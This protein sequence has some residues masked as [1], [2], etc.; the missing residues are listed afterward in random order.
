MS[1]EE[2]AA[3]MGAGQPVTALE[4]RSPQA[5]GE[6]PQ[7]VRGAIGIGRDR[8]AI[9]PSWPRDRLTVVYGT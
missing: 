8:L 1:A 4:A 9:D 5:W 3:R 2:V 6:S 7:K